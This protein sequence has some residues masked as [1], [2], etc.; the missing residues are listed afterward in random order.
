MTHDDKMALLLDIAKQFST[1]DNKLISTQEELEAVTVPDD[2]DPEGFIKGA[3]YALG[4]MSMDDVYAAINHSGYRHAQMLRDNP[5]YCAYL[6]DEVY[7]A[8][9]REQ[10]FAS[11]KDWE[12]KFG[13][14]YG[15]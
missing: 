7:P 11:V 8:E 6:R 13:T 4:G 3:A 10:Y 12:A 15:L 2:V 9:W 5:D 1:L 14:S